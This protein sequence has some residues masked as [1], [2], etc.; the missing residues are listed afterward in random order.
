MIR[1]V[2]PWRYRKT[3][4]VHVLLRVCQIRND[5]AAIDSC[6]S[7]YRLL[8]PLCLQ[9]KRV[10]GARWHKHVVERGTMVEK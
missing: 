9:I 5:D 10:N 7:D 8:L 3:G 1:Y 2:I 6:S 4:Y